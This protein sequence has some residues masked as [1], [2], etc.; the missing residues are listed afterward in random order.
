MDEV[1]PGV[2]DWSAF[3]E[4]IRQQVH[5]HYLRASGTLIDPMLP[6]GGA[7]ALREAGAPDRIVLTIRHHRRHSDELVREFGCPVLV[8]EEGADEVP[9][10]RPYAVGDEVAPG[11]RAVATGGW[12]ADDTVL[13]AAG[14]GLLVIAD[15]VVRDPSGALAFVP[16]PLLGD[17]PDGVRAEVRESLR[18]LLELDFDHL[19][20]AHGPPWIGGGKAALREFAGG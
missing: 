9:G 18:P 13:H 1:L 10:A 20:F 3:H 19:L 7:E 14:E 12:F 17:D 6:R 4:G 11:V 15:R 16:D 8:H 5:S 2:F